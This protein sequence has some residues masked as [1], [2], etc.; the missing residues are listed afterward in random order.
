MDLSKYYEEICKEPILSKEEEEDLFLE[1]ADEGL[2]ERRREAIKDRIIRAN[3]RF[4]FRQAKNFSKNDPSLFEELIAAGNEGLI[5]GME[6]FK[7]STGY[8]FLTYAGFW[9]QQRI[10]KQMASLRIVSLPIWKQQLAAKIQRFYDKNEAATFE[11]LKSFLPD[12]AEKDLKELSQTKYL[13]YYIDDVGDD[14]AFEINPIEET[15][16]RR[17]DRDRLHDVIS[18]LPGMHSQVIMLSYG[19]TD[20]IDRQQGEIADML[21]ISKDTLR[22][23]KKEAL[24][25][26]KDL[27][28]SD[29][30]FNV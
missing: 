2:S 3:L 1:L 4:V 8:R 28:G 11:D 23:L 29:N 10:L 24:S 13:T 17:M 16:N 20:G 9:V 21:G 15:V 14:P 30:P 5:V 26:L 12:V 22:K 25:Q 7:P 6:K 19:L 27:L 18:T